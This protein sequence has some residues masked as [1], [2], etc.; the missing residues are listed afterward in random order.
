M[1]QFFNSTFVWFTGVVEDVKDPEMMNRVRVRVMGLHTD[2]KVSIPTRDLPWATVMMPT[3]T[4]GTSGIGHSPHFL[5]QGSWVVGFFRDSH[6]SQDPVIMGTVAAKQNVKRDSGTGFSDP[7]GVYPTDE[8]LGE[9]DVNRLA[10]AEDNIQST[11]ET[12]KGQVVKG[13]KTPTGTWDEPVTPYAP[14]YPMNHVTETESGHILE[15]D[16]TEGAERIHEYH[17]S[18]TFREIHPDGSE[19]IRIVKDRYSVVIENDNCYVKGD[20]NLTVDSNCNMYI[21]GDWNVDV[22]GDV[23]I[24]IKGVMDLDVVGVITQDSAASIYLNKDKG[25]AKGAARIDD[26]ADTGDEAAAKSFKDNEAGTDKIETG[27][28]SVFIGN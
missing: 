16:D 22:D 8:L 12:K 1:D 3:T 23:N 26:T 13:V 28:G 11:V 25:G 19:V 10:R 27:S 15:L 5:L 4:P 17:K 14:T 2:D 6:T 7:D 24:D 20:V 18:G 21:K 9:P